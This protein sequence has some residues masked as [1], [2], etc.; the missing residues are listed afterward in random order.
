MNSGIA[1]CLWYDGQAEQAAEFYTSLIPN[2]EIESIMR[3]D[4]DGPALMIEFTLDGMAFQALNGGPEFRFTEAVSVAVATKDQEETDRLWQALT[5]NGG[6]ES[7]CG[8]LKDR[9]GLSWQIVPEILPRLIGS[10]DK[11]AAER[12]MRAMLTMRKIDIAALE[13]AY[14][15]E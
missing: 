5:S 6:A 7:Q 9:F 11:P 15:G 10:S 13:T 14:R 12:A 3:P 4:P 2:S 1:T 8:W